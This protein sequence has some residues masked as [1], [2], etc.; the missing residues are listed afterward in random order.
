M[1][2]ISPTKRYC[3]LGFSILKLP[4]CPSR[5]SLLQASYASI[6]WMAL[7]WLKL[8]LPNGDI[9]IQFLLQL[10]AGFQREGELSCLPRSSMDSSVPTLFAWF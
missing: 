10:W 3:L 9:L 7:D 4:F 1:L 6:L 8:Q 5:L 2:S